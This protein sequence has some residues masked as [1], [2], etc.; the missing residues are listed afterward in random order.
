MLLNYR[1]QGRAG[2]ETVVLLHGWPD[3]CHSYSRVLARIPPRHHAIAPDLRGFG[4][5]DKPETGYTIP[6]LAGDVVALLDSLGIERWTLVG[7]SFGSF[8]A[9]RV[10]ETHPGRVKRLVL[11]GSGFRAANDVTRSVLDELET[12]P[13]PVPESFA[14]AF[15]AATIHLLLPEDFFDELIR[16]S[17]KLPSRLWAPLLSGLLAFEDVEA[18][19]TVQ[20][21]TLLMWGERDALFSRADQDQLLA[22]LPDARLRIYEETGHCPNWERPDAVAADIL[23]FIDETPAASERS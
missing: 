20:C 9:R 21:P 5:S 14:R 1:S 19:G 12:L 15:Q 6:E 7:H 23:R 16:E 17:L 2:D 22:A 4:D 13:D 10:A 3:S 8:V 11:I 18:L